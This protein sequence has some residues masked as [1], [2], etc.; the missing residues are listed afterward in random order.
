MIKFDSVEYWKQTTWDR[1]FELKKV[2]KE[3][4]DEF[5]HQENLTVSKI[6]IFV[7]NRE[8]TRILDLACGTGKISESILK[9]FS[10]HTHLWLVDFNEQTLAI[11]K[12]NLT[13][14]QNVN[15]EL[16]DAY[17][18]GSKHP[19]YFDVIVALD[20]LHHVS[21]LER[22]LSSIKDALKDDGLFIANV[23]CA[24]RYSKWDRLKYGFFRS[25]L[26]TLFRTVSNNLY[27][28][29]TPKIQ[30]FIRQK[31]LARIEPLS[32]DEINKYIGRY[33]SFLDVDRGYYFWFSAKK[34][35]QRTMNFKIIDK[36]IPYDGFFRL[37]RYRLQHKLFSG[38]WSDELNREVFV[39]GNA[40]AVLPYDPKL[41]S[42]VLIEQFRVGAIC[43]AQNSWLIEIIAG[44]IEG[45]DSPET[46][47]IKE[48]QEEAGCVVRDLI[49]ITNFYTSPGGSS[50]KISLFCGR[51]DAS[52]AHGIHGLREEG[53]DIRASVVTLADAIDM[54]R[55]QKIVAANPLIA[56]LW[57]K[58]N[59][60]EVLNIW[61]IKK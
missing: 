59:K 11:A 27:Q 46:V 47:A 4:R 55:H 9:H 18:I 30:S 48:S 61:G 57:L 28:H 45:D 14:C 34:L 21:D 26:R 1:Y 22:M 36:Q 16:L 44:R 52:T 58:L 7:G 60:E 39:P 2:K 42:V 54:V 51:V 40:V 50:Q 20:F 29:V 13:N 32:K 56:I 37:E 8:N 33:F 25:S 43:D 23:F 5:K 12:Q 38:G 3:V 15:Y 10:H 17:H 24:E 41:D 31:G 6:K 49:P 53:E 35:K 19:K